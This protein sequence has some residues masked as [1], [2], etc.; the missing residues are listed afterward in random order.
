MHEKHYWRKNIRY[1]LILLSIW[2]LVSYG[3]AIFWKD[4]LDVIC[5]GGAGLGFWMA[6]QGAI[7]VFVLLIF[8]Y[9]WLMNKEESRM[10]ATRNPKEGSE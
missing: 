1:V 4:A 5:I 3:G 7:Y 2:F 9:V 10:S 6:Q 8:I